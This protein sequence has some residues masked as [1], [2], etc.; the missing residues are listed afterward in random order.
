[1]ATEAAHG[2]EQAAEGGLVF[3][4]MDQFMVKPLFG[5]GDVGMFT[6]TNVTLWMFLCI[7]AIIGV[8]VLGTSRRAIIPSRSQSVAELAY[9]FIYKMIEDVTG[10][11]GLKYF[12]YI[13]TLF[14]FIVFSNFLGLIPMSFTTTSH[15]A[16]T[17]VLALAVFLGVTIL[18][19]VKNGVHFL[20]LF[21]VSSAPLALRPILAVIE[22]I[23]YFV[24]PVSHSIRLAGNVMAG[25]A[26]MKV[27]AGFAA[28]AVVSPVSIVAI[29]A[30][31]GL[32][33]L[34]AFIQAYVFTILTCVYLKDALHPA[35]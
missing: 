35:H 28:L 24:R 18:G 33:V 7:L 27:F 22:V 3:H 13:M 4:P 9:G 6:I 30:I 26:V 21:W 12:P 16:V 10:K 20:G 8:M 23:S 31:Y 19:F 11:E 1:M 15:I 29:T 17:W 14:M 25:H 5:A 2:A 34:V 32:E